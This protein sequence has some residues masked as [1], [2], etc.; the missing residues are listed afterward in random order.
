MSESS[1]TTAP[2][3]AG[4]KAGETPKKLVLGG[5]TYPVEY[6]VYRSKVLNLE[7]EKFEEKHKLNLKGYGVCDVFYKFGLDKWKIDEMEEPGAPFSEGF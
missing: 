5:K 4:F 2:A 3:Y 1:T 6:I 7:T